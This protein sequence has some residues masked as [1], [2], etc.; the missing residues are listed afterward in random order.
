MNLPLAAV[1]PSLDL[2]QLLL[3][4]AQDLPLTLGGDSDSIAQCVRGSEVSTAC[5]FTN[6]LSSQV[7][8]VCDTSLWV[9]S[10]LR[11]PKGPVWI[12]QSLSI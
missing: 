1:H 5:H 4:L 10:R 12:P 2:P 7:S 6:P 11:R 8:P 9:F 3:L